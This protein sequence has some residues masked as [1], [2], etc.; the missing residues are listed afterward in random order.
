LIEGHGGDIYR[1]ARV[2]NCSPSQIVDMSSNVSP[3]GM[4]PGLEDYLRQGLRELI[5]L[6]EVDSEELRSNFANKWNISEN[7]VVVGNG[8]TEFIYILPVALGIKKALIV[9]PTYADYADACAVFNVTYSFYLALEENDFK[10][11][12]DH[13]E[14]SLRG[15]DTVFICNPNNPTGHLIPGNTLKE[16][17]ED[18][19]EKIFIVDESY[20]PFVVDGQNET[21][22]NKALKNVVVLRSFSKIF[23]IPG[24]RLGF[25][26]ASPDIIQKIGRHK[27]PWNVN[28]LAQLA[29]I[30][31]LGQ[32]Q[33][34]KD[35]GHFT[36]KERTG[37]LKQL[38]D[39]TGLRPF[40]G[41]TNF[42][43]FKLVGRL[44]A[45]DVCKRL[46]QNRILIRDCSNFYGLSDRFIRIALKTP[47]EN[48]ICIQRLR[49]ILSTGNE[50]L[51]L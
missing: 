11:N 9:G 6:P 32:D 17:C 48:N 37:F 7:Q 10:P 24:L 14:L 38:R 1:M 15:V 27:R 21:L 23:G 26:S 39:V 2:L 44:K 49:D 41:V 42:I 20:L 30:F 4:P 13:V 3:L 40:S 18:N 8:T 31:L 34:I 19:P 28:R 47:E 5:S 50:V 25:L 22:I 36:K 12:I 46:A 43:L 35:V 33:F 16:L 51:S 29:G 45:A